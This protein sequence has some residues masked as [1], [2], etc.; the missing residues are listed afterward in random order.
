M[1]IFGR[2]CITPIKVNNVTHLYIVW[3]S[4]W[5]VKQITMRNCQQHFHKIYCKESS[6]HFSESSVCQRIQWRNRRGSGQG[7]ECPLILLTGKFLLTYREKRGKE[8]KVKWRRKEWKS[9]KE[10]GKLKME[11]GKCTKWGEDLFSPF[12]FYYFFFLL[13]TFQHHWNLFWVY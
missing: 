9:K 5:N 1:L 11:G 6:M 7:A 4:T 2:R 10:G 13:F 3:K 12:F 8:K